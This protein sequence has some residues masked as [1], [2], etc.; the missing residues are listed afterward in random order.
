MTIKLLNKFTLPIDIHVLKS[1][2][3]VTAVNTTLLIMIVILAKRRTWV[4]SLAPIFLFWGIVT[5]LI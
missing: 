1:R 2:Y 3:Q 5:W 4:L